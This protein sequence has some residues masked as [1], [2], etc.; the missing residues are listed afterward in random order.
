MSEINFDLSSLETFWTLPSEERLQGFA[1]LRALPD[2]HFSAEA[3]YEGRMPAGPGYWSIVNHA[4]ILEVSRKPEL[5][6]S[7]RGVNV[8]DL[9]IEM[10]EFYGSMIAMDDPRHARLRKLVSAGFT[11]RM[12]A[13]LEQDVEVIAAQI[14]DQIA[15]AGRC[16]FVTEVS[17]QLPLKI[18]C[19]MMGVPD[20]YL[21]EVSRCTDI[22][23][24]GGDPEFIP[25][26]R[27]EVEVYIES[28]LQLA[29]IM[30]EVADSYVG[31]EDA[32]NLTSMLVNSEIDGEK[33]TRAELQSFFILLCSAGTET[34]RTATSWGLELLRRFPEQRS[35][36]Q[37]DVDGVT[38]TA[39]EEIVRHCTPVTH[40]RRTVTSDGAQ[41]GN[42]TFA[43]GEK[44]VL[45]Y[46]SA[47]RDEAV[48]DNADQF[49]VI[50]NPNP[51]VAYGG[52]GPHFCLGAHLARR[53]ISV[54]FRQ[55]FERL[56]DITAVG[57]VD[58]LRSSFINGIKHL[59]CEFTPV[60]A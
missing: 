40:M 34:T 36:W 56:P 37:A 1:Q 27:D 19:A 25:E 38:G 51:H 41:L 32:D 26:G 4:D 21:D 24:S 52:P 13:K 55:L 50:R 7:A 9:P 2:L 3:D 57:E 30:D 33:I 6:S 11:P 8:P 17:A 47:N 18:I 58:Q 15:G 31:K 48:F 59:E 42:H 35:I 29:A 14:I 39:V 43:A 49:N 12:L 10:L 5:F 60:G 44:L 20:S 46:N 16:D 53:E 23:L 54:M 28:G 22:I 45:W